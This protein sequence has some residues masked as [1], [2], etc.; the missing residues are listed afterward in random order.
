MYCSPEQ[1]LV[2]KIDD[3]QYHFWVR[4]TSLVEFVKVCGAVLSCEGKDRNK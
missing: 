4:E 1:E 3:L 2:K